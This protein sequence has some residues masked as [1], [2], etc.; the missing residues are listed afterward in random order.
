MHAPIVGLCCML[1]PSVV[2]RLGQIVV[3]GD[4][5]VAFKASSAIMMHVQHGIPAPSLASRAGLT[6]CVAR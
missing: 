2:A 1:A 5:R 3:E 4:E 6:C